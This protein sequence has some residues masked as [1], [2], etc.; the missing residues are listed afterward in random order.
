M[1]GKTLVVI[2][3]LAS[4]VVASGCVQET[5]T[6]DGSADGGEDISAQQEAVFSELDSDIIDESD[7]IEIGELI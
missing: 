6:T 7:T 4:V 1:K 5:P 3:L 2:L